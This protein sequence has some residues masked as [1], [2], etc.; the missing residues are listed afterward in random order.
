MILAV[1]SVTLMSV[2][3]KLIGPE[4]HPIQIAFAI[5]A[6][7]NGGTY[8]QPKLIKNNETIISERIFQNQTS[9]IMRKLSRLVVTD[10]SGSKANAEG[11]L[12][13]G[14]TGTAEKVVSGKYSKKKN[15]ASFVGI[16]PINDPK[17]LTLIMVDEPKGQKF[18]NHF[19]TGGWV[20]AP[21]VKEIVKK[22]ASILKIQPI[23][24]NLPSI[25]QILELNINDLIVEVKI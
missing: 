12:V 21:A 22:S 13:G 19:A 10:G 7:L 2:Q 3:A 25:K 24:E 11:Y 5:S 8:I 18:S 17:Y 1:L 15:L 9:L 4:Y 16:F 6:I 14:K 20:A 23:D